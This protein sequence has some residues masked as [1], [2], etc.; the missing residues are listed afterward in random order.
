[1]LN[2]VASIDQHCTA[3]ELTKT[4]LILFSR[5]RTK[6]CT[7]SYRYMCVYQWYHCSCQH[8][9]IFV[10]RISNCYTLEYII[11]VFIDHRPVEFIVAIMVTIFNRFCSCTIC[12]CRHRQLKDQY[13]SHGHEMKMVKTR[14]E[15]STHHQ[16]LTHLQQLR[17][18][19]GK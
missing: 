6:V 13:E 8:Y 3:S 16:Q 15:Q 12:T 1:M 14:M 9:G 5:P 19:I 11:R 10:I 17:D 7:I 18:N 4:H 2:L